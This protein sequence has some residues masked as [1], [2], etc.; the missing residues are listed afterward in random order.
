VARLDC[1]LKRVWI[2]GGKPDKIFATQLLK[3]YVNQKGKRIIA[4]VIG[5]RQLSDY[6]LEGT[7]S[8]HGLTPP[9]AI[10]D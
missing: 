8:A 1:H 9:R 5:I 3:S 4:F 6:H 7:P 10:T 2:G